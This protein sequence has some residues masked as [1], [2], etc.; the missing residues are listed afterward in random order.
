MK[1]EL[2]IWPRRNLRPSQPCPSRARTVVSPRRAHGRRFDRCTASD[3]RSRVAL[4]AGESVDEIAFLLG[5]RDAN[6]T[7]ASGKMPVT[8]GQIAI[9]SRSANP[10]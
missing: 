3:T 1:V 10:C 8:T 7:R 9:R 2:G 6:V 4:L 5:R